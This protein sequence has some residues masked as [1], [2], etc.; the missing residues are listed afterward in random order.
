MPMKKLMLVVNPKAGRGA[1]KANFGEALNLLQKGGY[2]TTLFFTEDRGDAIQY[3]AKYAADFDTVACIGGDGTL[4]EV[5]SGLMQVEGERP[6]LGYFPMGTA[7]DV[8]TTLS[9]PKNDILSAAERLLNGTA[10]PYDVGGFGPREHFAYIAAFG[11]FTEASYATPQNQKKMLGNLAYVLQGAMLLPK[12]QAYHTIVEYDDGVIEANLM[13]GSMSNS[14]SAAGI[15]RLP[16]QFVSLGD[17]RSEL[18]LIKDPGNI[19]GIRE[20]LASVITQRYDSDKLLLLH[21]RHAK[22]TFDQ[23][24][25]WTRDGEAGGEFRE[26]ELFNYKAPIEMIF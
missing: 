22:F 26:I 5:M 8:A 10:H 9:L 25:A 20:L 17:G 19:E 6:K 3:T 24:I 7:N 23:P 4:S 15:F 16:E 12:I 18:V 11:A 2:C 1:Y 13:Y 21:T 14:T